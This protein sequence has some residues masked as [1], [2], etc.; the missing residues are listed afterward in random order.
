[1]TTATAAP[2]AHHWQIAPPASGHPSPA[3]CQKCGERRTFGNVYVGDLDAK[4]LRAAVAPKGA[5]A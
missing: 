4:R 3:Q 2:C 1:M 5:K